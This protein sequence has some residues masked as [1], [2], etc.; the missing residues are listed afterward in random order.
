M[1]QFHQLAKRFQNEDRG[2]V[3][4][5]FG[6]C[7]LVLIFAFG[8]AVDT[9]RAI[10]V[11]SKTSSALDSAALAA[12]RAMREQDLSQSEVA[13]VANQYFNANIKDSGISGAT[14]SAL[15]VSVDAGTGSVRLDVTGSVPATFT[16]VA[17]FNTINV[18]RSSTAI[19]NI[20][21]VELGMMLD[22]TGS[23]GGS[24]ISDL[25]KAAK[26]LVNIMISNNASSQN[27]RIGLA[28]YSAS[29]NAGP[30]AAS[31]T[32]PLAPS[33]DGC[34]I[35]RTGSEAYEDTAPGA[36]T[37]INAANPL[38][39]PADIDGTDGTGS[40]RCPSVS[41]MPLT[42]DDVALKDRIDDF[43]AAGWTSGHIGLAW[44]WYLV[45]PDWSGVWPGESS[46][47]NYLDGKTIKA[48]IL[49]TDGS[50]NTAYANGDSSDQA[51][52]ICDQMKG[53]DKGII[54]YS[55]AFEAPADAQALLQDC[56]TPGNAN[57]GQTYFNA[58]NG[59]ELR[60]AFRSIA[61]QLNTLRLSE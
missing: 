33:A 43:T 6:L 17:G 39:P 22:V 16:K 47:V 37:W 40:Y 26:D 52:N 31:V 38:A 4:I 5:I 27:V 59:N 48:V 23:M 7:V 11:S 53:A 15:D 45:S 2:S 42:D 54:V 61:T 18:S 28:P 20:R 46:P 25:R 55:I 34:V 21:D 36:G 29:V 14:Y 19:Y 24:K 49:M 13:A 60:E 50:F 44:A 35:E 10:Q 12:A 51:R 30:Y 32:D 41:I 8:M 58:K 1:K 56:S 9:G 57:V 3:A